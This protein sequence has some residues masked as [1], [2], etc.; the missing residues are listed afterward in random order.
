[1]YRNKAKILIGIVLLWCV[2]IWGASVAGASAIDD[3]LIQE[4][5]GYVVK[6]MEESGIPGLAVSIV[7]EG[8]VAYDRNFGYADVKKKLPVTNQTR[9][10]LGSTTKAF[11]A[12]GILNLEDEGKLKLTDTVEA[13]LPWFHMEF[14]GKREAIT[15][16]QLLH[17]TS[18]IPYNTIG[19]IPTEDSPTALEETVR[20]LV[21]TELVEKPGKRFEYATINYDILGY[22][23]Q[24]IS[25]QTYQDYIREH[26]LKPLALNGSVF[27]DEYDQVPNLAKGYKPA[28]YRYRDYSAPLY[29]GNTPAGYLITTKNDMV[30]WL[31]IQLGIVEDIPERLK[32]LVA[33]SQV[34]DRS[35]YPSM[36]GSSYAM[37]WSVFQIGSGELSHLGANPNYSSYF[38]FRPNDGIAVVV[39]ANANSDYTNLIGHNVM[40]MLLHQEVT[41]LNSDF[42]KKIDKMSS[43]VTVLF[44]GIGLLSLWML[45]RLVVD[46]LRGIRRYVGLSFKR[47][48][49]I[50]S[51]AAFVLSLLIAIY[52]LPDVMFSGLP[53]KFVLVWGPLSIPS[54]IIAISATALIYYLYLAGTILFVKQNNN[55]L[56]NI[57]L[58]SIMSGFGNAFLIFV[59]NQ[60]LVRMNGDQ[61]PVGLIYY[62]GIG[63]LF[64]VA[65]QRLLRK[66]L[67]VITNDNLYRKRMQIID[68]ILRSR[69]QTVEKYGRDKIMASLNN[70]TEVVSTSIN[71]VIGGL[72]N[73]VTLICC[74]VYLGT[75]SLPGLL[76]SVLLIGLAVC[77]YAIVSRQ[78]ERIW[79]ETRDMQN[80]FFRFIN[81]LIYGFKELSMSTRK[82][83]EFREDMNEISSAYRQK[84]AQGDIAFA[85][86]FV[87]GELL[88][89]IVIGSIAFLLPMLFKDILSETL[90]G[91]VFVFLYMTGPINGILNCIPQAT[92]MKISWKRINDLLHEV[93]SIAPS[94][95]E[96][97]AVDRREA[98]KIDLIDVAFQYGGDSSTFEIG[99]ISCSFAKGQIVF[100]TGG[101]GSGKTTFGKLL[102][103][104][105]EPAAGNIHID[106]HVAS[107]ADIGEVFSPVFSD[108]HLFEKL[109]GIDTTGRDSEVNRY[110]TL[111][112]LE[113]KVTVLNNEFSTIDLSA[114][115]RKRL[116]LFMSYLDDRPFL[117]FDEWAADQDPEFRRFFYTELL[118]NLRAK[119]KGIIAITH[120]DQYYGV[121]DQIMKFE[122]GKLKE[123]TGT[124]VD[125]NDFLPSGETLLTFK[126][127]NS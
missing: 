38:G 3:K 120:D 94:K 64:Y 41:S 6:L 63:L 118:P 90:R 109:Y 78:A 18:G 51:G 107:P 56:V 25:G 21:G 95:E 92:Q 36:D 89:T 49:F 4:I 31:Q 39:M 85:N 42:Y 28:F 29:T 12:L 8:Q 103:G 35:V 15:I 43:S 114:G 108:Y 86:V 116:A 10:E 79:E 53:W 71:V 48:L 127:F 122:M 76:I 99:P 91:F 2:Q 126:Y 73:L 34:P 7:Q 98:Q 74:L 70:D 46:I 5:D 20:R 44:I 66:R 26:I 101:N 124:T 121:A 87:L 9:F 24:T 113:E 61:W 106:G 62:F 19:D 69:Y 47:I 80:A 110:L 54:A 45:A 97:T 52:F 68:T 117:F 83:R 104:L 55:S 23:I 33:K 58:M 11:T 65:G 17:H 111:L 125:A 102:T 59:I 93:S 105:Y 119:G 81:H 32:K 115:Q 123:L 75:L 60:Q 30:R 72:T 77:A 40:R 82:R 67:I 57:T 22:I 37:G 84:R 50:V 13:Y 16:G 88:F 1:M 100:I 27:Y 96:I 112:G 14:E